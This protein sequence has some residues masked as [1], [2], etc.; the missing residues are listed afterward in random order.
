MKT[1]CPM[2]FKVAEFASGELDA[3]ESHEFNAHLVGCPACRD[4]LQEH[5]RLLDRLRSLPVVQPVARPGDIVAA[6]LR[7]QTE[8][9]RKS[10]RWLPISA[11][12]AAV[13]IIGLAGWGMLRPSADHGTVSRPPLEKP[14]ADQSLERALKWLETQQQSDGSWDVRKWGGRP[15]FQVALSSLSTLAILNAG[16]I[17]TRVSARAV[18]WLIGQQGSD[19]MFGPQGVGR[20]F[21]QS[22]ATLALLQASRSRND[23]TLRTSIDAAISAIRR[24]QLPDGGWGHSGSVESNDTVT[25]WHVQTLELAAR[26]GWAQAADALE[27]G[28]GCLARMQDG[29]MNVADP[30]LAISGRLDMCSIYF[31]VLQLGERNDETSRKRLDALRGKLIDMQADSGEDAGSWPPDSTRHQVGGRL[32]S[33][34]LAALTLDASH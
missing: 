30:A 4:E 16:N 2:N 23:E 20:P 9:S 8:T 24:S 33:T 12:A 25:T 10:A 17:D 19:G 15:E 11:A 3:A 14:L 7:K 13:A 1:E 31:T 29:R 28:R 5:R 34:S 27:R 18:D 32:F 26:N 6:V 22:L 21:N